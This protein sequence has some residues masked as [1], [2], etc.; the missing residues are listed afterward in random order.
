VVGP[1][2]W[3]YEVVRLAKR[4]EAFKLAGWKRFLAA[5]GA[6]SLLIGVWFIIPLIVF[7]FSRSRLQLYILPLFVPL[8]LATARSVVLSY[9]TRVGMRRSIGLAVVSIVLIVAGKAAYTRIPSH[10]DM[11]RLYR[12][13][14]SAAGGDAVFALYRERGLYGLEF[15]AAGRIQRI[16]DSPDENWADVDL[17]SFVEELLS[18]SQRGAHVVIASDAH[19]VRV[20]D[21]LSAAGLPFDETRDTGWR[22]FVVNRV[23]S[24]KN[25]RYD[26]EK[27]IL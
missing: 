23:D 26:E 20:R 4:I 9:G 16:S 18:D 21:A 7:F 11:G 3:L 25:A 2:L 5:R 15:Y 10:S 13:A 6:P 8:A 17:S 14:R 12:T 22:I 19:A 1:G 27:P 24:G